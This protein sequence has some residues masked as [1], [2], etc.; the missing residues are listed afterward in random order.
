MPPLMAGMN[1]TAG[2]ALAT[3]FEVIRS[4][5]GAGVRTL[6]RVLSPGTAL[7]TAVEVI[8]S[9]SFAGVRTLN[10]IVQQPRR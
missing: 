8:G 9:A 3:A 10:R 1:G 4:T 6:N 5:S 7:S 2:T